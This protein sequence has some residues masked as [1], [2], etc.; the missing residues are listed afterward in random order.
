[1]STAE[2]IGSIVE[3]VAG[4]LP[5]PEKSLLMFLGEHATTIAQIVDAIK[6]G[7]ETKSI[8]GFAENAMKLISDLEMKKEFPNG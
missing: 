2:T 3:N 8:E 4:F 7:V 1:M 5:E 6:L